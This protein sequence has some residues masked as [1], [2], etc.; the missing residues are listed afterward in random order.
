MTTRFSVVGSP[1]E[2]SLSP[3]LHLAAYEHLGLDFVYE[4]NEVSSGRLENF[5]A[6]DKFAGVSVTMPLKVEAFSLAAGHDKPSVLTGVSN[7]LYKSEGVWSAANTDVYGIKQALAEVPSPG[8]TVLIGSGATARSAVVAISEK[9][10]ATELSI[11][12]RNAEAGTSLAGF[13]NDLGLRAE[14]RAENT[15]LILEADLVASV[16]PAGSYTELWGQVSSSSKNARGF[17]FDTAYSPWPSQAARTW[18]EPRVISG[19]EMLIWQAI[20]QV[21]LFAA[22]AEVEVSLDHAGLY[23][24]MKK[25]VSSP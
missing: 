14:L 7:T 12:S 4:K 17:L 16:V 9:F 15:D 18:D 8:L 6:S 19:L 5:L 13:A 2:H 23:E 10:P 1:I 20:E 11:I 25:S 24:V 3:M 22:A 21:Q